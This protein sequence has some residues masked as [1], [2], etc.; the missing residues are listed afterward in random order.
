[1]PFYD[2]MAAT[3]GASIT[4]LLFRISC[5]VIAIT[6]NA[7]AYKPAGVF[8]LLDDAAPTSV[9]ATDDAAA[10]KFLR[11]P[12]FDH[13]KQHLILEIMTHKLSHY[14]VRVGAALI[15]GDNWVFTGV[16]ESTTIS[17]VRYM[18]P[19]ATNAAVRL[20]ASDKTALP[21]V[22]GDNLFLVNAMFVSGL[23]V[24]TVKKYPVNSKD[25]GPHELRVEFLVTTS[26]GV[27][28]PRGSTN[29]KLHTPL[30]TY[31]SGGVALLIIRHNS[32]QASITERL[33]VTDL[34]KLYIMLVLITLTESSR[35]RRFRNAPLILGKLCNTTPLE[36][37]F[38]TLISGQPL[39][40][41][42]DVA[43]AICVLP[44]A[45]LLSRS[46]C[47]VLQKTVNYIKKILKFEREL[48]AEEKLFVECAHLMT[49]FVSQLVDAF[50]ATEVMLG[51][52][53]TR[54]VAWGAD[55]GFYGAAG[56]AALAVSG[57]AI[58]ALLAVD[59]GTRYICL[60]LQSNKSD[61]H[62]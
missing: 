54:L 56:G 6:L 3:A 15:P 1:M 13:I 17:D 60:D 45:L 62:A 33:P 50:A 8:I 14:L 32:P 48:S 30:G 39:P 26:R 23:R 29:I 44:Y 2:A 4:E 19:C 22:F 27:F 36:Q 24:V 21:E 38:G 51:K 53:M 16:P 47:G 40:P 35:L 10:A 41:K 25:R 52:D 12:E 42:V 46:F 28:H 9:R 49:T 61:S 18:T 43:F 11:L 20:G 5:V 7:I 31:T 34:L 55:G 57:G 59:S 58:S 37:L